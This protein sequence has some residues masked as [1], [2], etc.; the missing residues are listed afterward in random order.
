[1]H[2]GQKEAQKRTLCTSDL[3]YPVL[4]KV[5]RQKQQSFIERIIISCLN[6]KQ[7]KLHLGDKNNY[8]FPDRIFKIIWEDTVVGLA[9]HYNRK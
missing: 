3:H 4:S 6:P 8:L 2:L 1:M 9:H 7:S 5:N